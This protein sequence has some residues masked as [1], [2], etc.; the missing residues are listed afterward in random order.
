MYMESKLIKTS[1]FPLVDQEN[2]FD[3]ILSIFKEV[4]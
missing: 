3:Y 2:D 4:E 1:T